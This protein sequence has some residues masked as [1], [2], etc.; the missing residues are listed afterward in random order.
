MLFVASL[1]AA[2]ILALVGGGASNS[3]R[4]A[5]PPIGRHLLETRGL[6]VYFENRGN[7]NGWS[8]GLLVQQLATDA[9]MQREVALQLDKMQALG[10]N[11]IGFELRSVG[12]VVGNQPPPD[13]R[14]AGELGA[15]WPDPLPSE[16]AGLAKLLDLLDAREMRLAL[17]LTNTHHDAPE[18]MQE[19]WFGPLLGVVKE[20]PALDFVTFDGDV[21][22]HEDGGCGGQ[23]EAALWNGPGSPTARYVSNAIRYGIEHGMSPRTLTAE[24]IVP[25]PW[26]S[27]EPVYV[28]KVIFDEFGVPNEERTYALSNYER[29]PTP[30]QS[31]DEAV[32]HAYAVIG[33]TPGHHGG[34][35]VVLSEFGNDYPIPAA[36]PTSHVVE[37]FG[38]LMLKYGMEGGNFW[39]W[40]EMNADYE[41]KHL[42]EA[43]KRRGWVF[44]YNPV[45]AEIKDLYG[46]HLESIP[47][48]S[49]EKGWRAGWTLSGNGSA[50]VVPFTDSARLSWR[51][52]TA[53][54]LSGRAT[55]TLTSVPLRLS[56]GTA[57]TTTG[58]FR[59][60]RRGSSVTFRYLT[61][62]GASSAQ[63]ARTRFA[64]PKTPVRKDWFEALPFR[65][66]TPTD[67]CF[68]RIAISAV[69]GAVVVDNLR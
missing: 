19:R 17:H 37:S 63:R 39:L 13:C 42:A 22:L 51:G 20:D 43:V 6:R 21:S 40:A 58:D 4:A 49:F 62:A 18:S 46:F 67:A 34:P 16:L 25:F 50:S 5:S 36:W 53:L 54:R 2:T 66:K 38:V 68:V 27:W 45:A 26:G 57:Y 32:A 61:C 28:M 11:E 7:T 52:E 8:S 35:R 65:Y 64:L 41:A 48:G 29:G 60:T 10:V 56:S 3:G 47:G 31:S 12:D 69:R 24:T 55:V 33:K 14:L 59:V 44:A 15:H 23:S 1:A 30:H 9:A